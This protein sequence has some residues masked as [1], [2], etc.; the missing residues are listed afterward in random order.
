MGPGKAFDSNRFFIICANVAGSPY[1][2]ISPVSIDPDTG[3]PYG[4]SFPPT[5][6][7]DDV[8]WVQSYLLVHI[9][10]H[11]ELT[12]VSARCRQKS[13]QVCFRPSGRCIRCSCDRRLNGRDVRP[14]MATL[15]TSGFRSSH[16]SH[17]DL[18]TTLRMVYLVG[19]DPTTVHIQR[20]GVRRRVLQGP[21]YLG[22][23]SSQD[24]CTPD[25]SFERFIRESVWKEGAGREE[26]GWRER[27]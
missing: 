25:V 9:C 11:P 27:R 6:I 22:S 21:T 2:T 4:P 16:H 10:N 15:H 23:R 20:P 14:R 5:S 12:I 8:L 18:R 19:R 26:E 17:R 13:P 7:R 24:G 3:E 1:G